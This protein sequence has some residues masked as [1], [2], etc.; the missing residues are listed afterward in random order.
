MASRCFVR[1]DF[2]TL[3]RLLG[4]GGKIPR[5]KSKK[6]MKKYMLKNNGQKRVFAAGGSTSGGRRTADEAQHARYSGVT[7]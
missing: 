3:L 1:Q 6:E 7:L 5:F 4:I 2:L